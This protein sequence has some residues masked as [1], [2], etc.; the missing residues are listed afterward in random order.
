MKRTDQP[1]DFRPGTPPQ[2]PSSTSPDEGWDGL[3]ADLDA[4]T[5]PRL[6]AAAR[7]RIWDRV[8]ADAPGLAGFDS[9]PGLAQLEVTGPTPGARRDRTS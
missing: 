8:Q 7:E 6:E 5:P 3:A 4:L 2:Q 1:D 9:V